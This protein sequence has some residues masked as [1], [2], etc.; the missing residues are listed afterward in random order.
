MASSDKNVRAMTDANILFS[1][2]AFPRWPR[3]VLRHAVKG[4]YKL[5]LCP[6]V[7]E[8]ARRNLQKRYPERVADLDEFLELT[9]YELVSDPSLDDINANKNLVRDLSDVAVALAAIVAKADYLISEDKDLTVQDETTAELRKHI[10]V[11]LSGTF[12]RE[13]MGWSSEDLEK[14]RH[15]KWSD[16]EEESKKKQEDEQSS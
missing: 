11:M 1:G 6:I 14:L 8:E 4:D 15:R 12:L 9:D 2:V 10:K 7:I 3:E 13:V 16:V 5:I